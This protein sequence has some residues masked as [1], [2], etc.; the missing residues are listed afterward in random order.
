VGTTS[1]GT[2]ILNAL[3]VGNVLTY[4]L[5]G[6]LPDN[7]VIYV[8]IVPYNG[9]G[10]ALGC[11]EE[12]FTTE[13]GCAPPPDFFTPNNDGYHDYWI[14]PNDCG[15]IKEI[16]IFDRYGKLLK[17]LINQYV[18][19]GWDGIYNNAQMPSSDYWYII[20]YEDGKILKGHFSLVL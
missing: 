6:D 11:L 18:Y 14:V 3:D 7:A 15:M 12:S 17:Q 8:S 20:Q 1:G 4:D 10:S 16:L 13:E 2:D 9:D 19:L 5:A